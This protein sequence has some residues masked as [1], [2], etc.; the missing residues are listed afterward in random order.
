[1]VALKSQSADDD[2]CSKFLVNLT[3]QGLLV[4]LARIHFASGEFPQSG[5][6]HAFWASRDEKRPVRLD[7]R[8][9]DDV[10]PQRQPERPRLSEF[11][12]CDGQRRR[13]PCVRAPRACL[14]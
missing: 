1:M 5:Q 10:N 3:G 13:V 12:T 9:N 7:N 2:P 14:A 4:R 8:R 6:V 11:V